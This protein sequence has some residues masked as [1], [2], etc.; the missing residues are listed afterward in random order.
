MIIFSYLKWISSFWIYLSTGTPYLK[1]LTA[2]AGKL[3]YT[4]IT[5]LILGSTA[6]NTL[7]YTSHIWS[8]L[9]IWQNEYSDVTMVANIENNSSSVDKASQK[10]HCW[11]PESPCKTATKKV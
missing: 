7:P 8:N 10:F 5:S 2:H 3:L 1:S 6:V 4:F 11:Q 9:D